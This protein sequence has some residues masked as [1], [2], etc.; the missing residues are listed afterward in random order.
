M[1]IGIFGIQERNNKAINVSI[2]KDTTYIC[3]VTT[4]SQEPVIEDNIM[5]NG[6]FEDISIPY[7]KGFLLIMSSLH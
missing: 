7:Y 1:D 2:Q 6:G 5:S 3:S 4:I